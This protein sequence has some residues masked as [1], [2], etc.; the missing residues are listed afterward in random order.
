MAHQAPAGG[1]VVG[2]DPVA[3][4]PL[5]HR[6]SG[7]VRRRGL[8]QAPLHRHHLVGPGPVEADGAVRAHRVLALVAVVGGVLRPQD[9]LHPDVRAPQALQGVL[10]PLAL[11]P[12]LLR[13]GQVLEVAPAAPAVIGALG[14]R[15][16]GRGLVDPH[17][18]PRR[19][20]LHHLCDLQVD[21]LSPDGAGHEHHGPVQADD[22]AALAGVALHRAGADLVFLKMFH[23]SS[24]EGT[25][26]LAGRIQ[27]RRRSLPAPGS[28]G[29][30]QLSHFSRSWRSW[31]AKRA[32]DLLS[33]PRLR[34]MDSMSMLPTATSRS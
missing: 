28:C 10:D 34:L 12:Q 23:R 29:P 20:G 14:R 32:R 5:P 7:G 3:A 21:G 26:P 2:G 9:L 22:A 31:S 24:S 13:V 1:L 4:H 25:G 19:R 18:L 16:V 11:G 27:P 33:R 6:R 8:D 30:F 15:P 17:D